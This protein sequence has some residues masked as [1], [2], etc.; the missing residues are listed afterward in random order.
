MA[1][2]VQRRWLVSLMTDLPAV[3]CR[4]KSWPFVKS[5]ENRSGNE[6]SFIPPGAEMRLDGQD[7]LK[8]WFEPSGRSR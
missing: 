2:R 5:Y 3:T 1:R 6:C 8:R 4:A 7:V